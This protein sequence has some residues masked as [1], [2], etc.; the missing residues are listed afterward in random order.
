VLPP[1]S[2]TEVRGRQLPA[3][4]HVRRSFGP[5]RATSTSGG[6]GSP[7]RDRPRQCPEEGLAA[8][9]LASAIQTADD[10]ADMRARADELSER[11]V[12]ET[13]ADRGSEQIEALWPSRSAAFRSVDEGP[14]ERVGVVGQ[15]IV[16]LEHREP[17][18]LVSERQQR[19][20]LRP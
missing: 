11:I 12:Q 3:S 14:L 15:G 5:S 16:G 20:A 8:N 19:G 10:D 13:G 17:A 1:L 4:R 2:I 9:R 18:L 6:C 7:C